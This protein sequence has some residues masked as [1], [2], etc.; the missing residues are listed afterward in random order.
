MV[1]NIV[2]AKKKFT[3][4]FLITYLIVLECRVEGSNF[5]VS[6]GCYHLGPPTV[7]KTL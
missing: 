5:D 4:G 2:P 1:S 7:S 3:R 6:A